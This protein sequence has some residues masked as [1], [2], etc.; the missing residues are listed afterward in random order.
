MEVVSEH[1]DAWARNTETQ[2]GKLRWVLSSSS[3]DR[4]G[5]FMTSRKAYRA[6]RE[7]RLSY[8]SGIS[9]ML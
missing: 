8:T 3:T 1:S 4:R 9:G 2:L 7:N 5:G 6:Y